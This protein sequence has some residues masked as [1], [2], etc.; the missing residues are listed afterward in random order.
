MNVHA[1]V[2][3]FA[4]FWAENVSQAYSRWNENVNS[5]I[6]D[7]PSL[8]WVL[9]MTDSRSSTRC[10]PPETLLVPPLSPNYFTDFRTRHLIWLSR[11]SY[12]FIN[13]QEYFGCHEIIISDKSRNAISSKQFF[14]IMSLSNPLARKS[15]FEHDDDNHWTILPWSWNF[16]PLGRT[17]A[18]S[19]FDREGC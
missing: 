7:G 15:F 18:K 12:C 17:R 8:E 2:C 13:I 5:R 14:G 10:W 16:E 3:M 11:R 19:Q 6:K 1:V 4:R 9:K